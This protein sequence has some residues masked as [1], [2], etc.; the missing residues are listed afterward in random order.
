VT[1]YVSA[2]EKRDLKFKNSNFDVFSTLIS[3]QLTVVMNVIGA[4]QVH[5]N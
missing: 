3:P 5:M 2:S 4:A 1:V